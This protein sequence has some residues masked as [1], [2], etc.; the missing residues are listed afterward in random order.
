MPWRRASCKARGGVFDAVGAAIF[1]AEV[2]GATV[3]ERDQELV[4][5]R[6]GGEQ[7]AEVADGDAH[8]GVVLGFDAGDAALHSIVIAVAMALMR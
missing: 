8:A 1:V 6:L 4:A 5:D 3:G 7:F 2:V